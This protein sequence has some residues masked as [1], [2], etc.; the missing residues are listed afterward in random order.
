MNRITRKLDDGRIAATIDGKNDTLERLWMY[1]N[2]GYEPE[3][4]PKKRQRLDFVAACHEYDAE[5]SAG[6]RIDAA[7]HRIALMQSIQGLVD[8][9]YFIGYADGVKSCKPESEVGHE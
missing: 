2:T 5:Q 3:E 7:P 6:Q 8:N 1:E 4:I 9:E